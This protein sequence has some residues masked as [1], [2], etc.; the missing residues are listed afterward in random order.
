LKISAYLLNSTEAGSPYYA[1]TQFL[2][3]IENQ[4]I[5]L[6][7]RVPKFLF[8]LYFDKLSKNK[9]GRKLLKI[10]YLMISWV[11]TFCM[12]SS[13]TV[14]RK[15]Q[16][17]VICREVFTSKYIYVLHPL[18][19]HIL[20]KSKVVWTIDDN[21]FESKEISKKETDLLL[22]YSDTIVVSSDYLINELPINVHEKVVYLHP[23]DGDIP[24]DL[25]VDYI[26]SK[27]NEYIC[28]INL[29]WIGSATNLK[30]LLMVADSLEEAA[31]ELQEKYSKKLN[32]YVVC[33]QPF[34]HTSN[35]LHVI[36]IKWSRKIAI[37]YMKIAHIG[38]MPLEESKYTK[39]KCSGK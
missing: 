29:I 24:Q 8:R 28:D 39:G 35:R 27:S 26:E 33:N 23:T 6:Y 18:Y 1:V 5:K 30:Y 15:P 2:R 25:H 34:E 9:M 21:I 10:I 22:K 38:L 12:L 16:I 13:D 7:D 17:V 32:L 4:N 20:K 19:K 3:N 37:E 14:V 31:Y 36:N 11:R